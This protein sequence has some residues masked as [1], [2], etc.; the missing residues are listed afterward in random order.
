MAA[1]LRIQV[2]ERRALSPV[3]NYSGPELYHNGIK[4]SL[5]PT[6]TLPSS[7]LYLASATPRAAD[8]K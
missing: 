7:F 8:T 5:H 3:G 4:N 1:E 2:A 6:S